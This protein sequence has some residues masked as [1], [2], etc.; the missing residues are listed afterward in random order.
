MNKAVMLKPVSVCGFGILY[1]EMQFDPV[2]HPEVTLPQ[3][4]RS[5]DPQSQ[6]PPVSAHYSPVHRTRSGRVV[7]RPS[8]YR[9]CHGQMNGLRNIK[10]EFKSV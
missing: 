8:R 1:N 2:E 3:S 4:P 9:L 5:V 7:T 10:R 6:C